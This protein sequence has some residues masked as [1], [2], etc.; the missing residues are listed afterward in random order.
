MHTVGC[1]L[2]YVTY[3]TSADVVAL[4]TAALSGHMN[5]LVG[6]ATLVLLLML[7][8]SI[9]KSDMHTCTCRWQ[10]QLD[11][12]ASADWHIC[13]HCL[14]VWLCPRQRGAR[15]WQPSQQNISSGE[16]AI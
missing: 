14:A 3:L 4:L 10:V 8:T 16:L 11:D 6:P 13:A 15:L 5:T 9:T 1:T 2:A 12:G 7:L